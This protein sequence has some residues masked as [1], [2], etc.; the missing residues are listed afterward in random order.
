MEPVFVVPSKFPPS[1]EDYY[2]LI[3]CSNL[4]TVN[5]YSIER[6]DCKYIVSYHCETSFVGDK[7]KVV[8]WFLERPSA[9]GGIGNFPKALNE[10]LRKLSIDEVW[11]SDRHLYNSLLGLVQN[12]KFVPVGSHSGLAKVSNQEPIYDAIDLCYRQGRRAFIDHLR[13]RVAPTV[14]G[15]EKHHLLSKSK[16]MLN[17][18][19]DNCQYIE[20]LRFALGASYGLPIISESCYDSYPFSNDDVIFR[21]YQDIEGTLYNFLQNKSFC[22][23]GQRIKEKMTTEFSFDKNVYRAVGE[24]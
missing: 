13:C 22:E 3:S 23:L 20:P 5:Q 14:Y 2:S 17:V 9:F 1:Y 18:H 8:L 21:P 11:V 16:V 4:R 19:Q 7:G 12:I 24:L 6:E 15:I 10:H